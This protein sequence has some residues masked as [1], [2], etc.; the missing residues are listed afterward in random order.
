MPR[1]A[2]KL[3]KY[4]KKTVKGN[5]YA[6]VTIDGTDIYLGPHGSKTSVIEYDRII[7]EYLANGRSLLKTEAAVGFHQHGS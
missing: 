3:P 2:N 5:T 1:L 7:A 6:V 4:R